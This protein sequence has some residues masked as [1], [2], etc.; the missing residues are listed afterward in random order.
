MSARPGSLKIETTC[1]AVDVETLAREVEAGRELTLHC[2]EIDFFQADATAG[3]KLVFVGGLALDLVAASGEFTDEGGF[4][5][6]GELRPFL[7]VAD[8][9]GFDETFPEAAGELL[10]DFAFDLGFAFA[11]AVE[12]FAYLIFRYLA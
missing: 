8:A 12:L 4:L 7:V 3:D 2:F 1:D 5:V 11:Q 10:E 6:F 9:G